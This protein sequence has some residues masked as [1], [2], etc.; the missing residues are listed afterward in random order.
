MFNF[1]EPLILVIKGCYLKDCESENDND[2]DYDHLFCSPNVED[3][4]LPSTF[5]CVQSW[6]KSTL[7]PCDQCKLKF[8]T[9]PIFTPTY[10]NK[11][12]A[13]YVIGVSNCFCGF[14]CCLKYNNTN[15]KNMCERI[16][17]KENIIF[18]YNIFNSSI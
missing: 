2:S 12:E 10:I 8:D 6:V 17:K 15:T 5:R 1:K 7:I 14:N 9:M 16:S 13:N 11:I 3:I 4:E 18:L